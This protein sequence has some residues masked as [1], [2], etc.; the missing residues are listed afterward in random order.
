MNIEQKENK[1]NMR[2]IKNIISIGG[3]GAAIGV[4]ALT[5]CSNL[6]M[7][8][9]HDERSEGRVADDKKITKNIEGKLKEDATYKFESVDVNTYGG[10]VQLSGFVNDQEQKRRAEDLARRVDGVTQIVNALVIKPGGALSP[11]GQPTGQHLS[12]PPPGGT[13]TPSTSPNQ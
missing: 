13:T 9:T 10:I 7:H 12:S 4:A 6:D 1:G 5:G 8:K 2:N 11:T 3:I